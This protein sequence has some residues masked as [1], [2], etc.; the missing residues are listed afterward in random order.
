MRI[1]VTI[2]DRLKLSVIEL[3]RKEKILRL[4]P[5]KLDERLLFSI[6]I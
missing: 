2:F 6:T 4:K 5:L 1:K 3:S